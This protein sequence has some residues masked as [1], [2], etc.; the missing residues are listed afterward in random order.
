MVYNDMVYRPEMLS[1][2][3]R[4]K[5]GDRTAKVFRADVMK[6]R[7]RGNA[8]GEVLSF[9]GRT[10]AVR[11]DRPI[12]KTA[13]PTARARQSAPQN[14]AR[15]NARP[16]RPNVNAREAAEARARAQRA[17]AAAREREAARVR[18]ENIRRTRPVQN[19]APQNPN[20]YAT[21]YAMGERIRRTAAEYANVPK[22]RYAVGAAPS[23]ALRR[24]RS[25]IQGSRHCVLVT[26]EEVRERDGVMQH[27]AS[28]MS[29]MF[30]A[31]HIAEHRTK[32]TP[33]P[34]ATCALLAICTIMV[35][36]VVYSFSQIH[37][38]SSLI[39]DYKSQQKEL[40]RQATDLEIALEERDDIRNIEK[41]ATEDIGMVSSDMVQSRFVSVA[42]P[43]RVE[44][45]KSEED[46]GG[47]FSSL[48]SVLGEKLGW[49][50]DYFG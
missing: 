13:R 9:F 43:D 22:R 30:T 4:A 39:N 12:P 14:V 46:S 10:D 16:A 23:G 42:T 18:A 33:V 44:V 3:L 8:S 25:N 15:A 21:A 31:R 2:R 17:N 1:E 34:F 32:R 19:T 40:A 20:A 27:F 49:V 35:M 5:F 6:D 37:E 38:Y 50:G 11:A 26:S 41:T 29:S 28:V 7:E 47:A 45:V 36:V 48:L 24:G